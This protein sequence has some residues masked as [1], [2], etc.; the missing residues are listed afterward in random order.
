MMLSRTVARPALLRRF[1]STRASAVLSSLD[2]PGPL[3]DLPG[4]YDGSWKGSGPVITSTCPT[5]GEVLANIRS[6]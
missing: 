4:V 2:F 5:T 1:L 6:V 3:S